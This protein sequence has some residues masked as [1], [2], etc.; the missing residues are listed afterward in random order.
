[1]ARS[2]RSSTLETRAARLR[3]PVARKPV[4][5][6]IGHGIGLG[7]R[8]NKTAGTWV[9]RVSDGKGGNWTKAIGNADDYDDADGT[10]TID[11]WQAQDKAR[12]LGRTERT[13]ETRSA[14]PATV[15]QALDDYEADLKTRGADAG[16][17]TRV[18]SHLPARLLDKAVALLL[19][20]EL[21]NWRDGLAGQLAAASVNR[22]ATG[23]KAALNLAAEQ[24]ARIA[25]RRA[26]EAGLA[27]IPD[28]EQS[29]NVILSET[30]VRQ[31]IVA[32][33]WQSAEFGLLI[34]VAAVTGARV[35]QLAQIEVQDLQADRDAPRLMMPTSRKGK[36]KKTVQRRPVPIPPRLAAKLRVLTADGPATA[37]LLVKPSG[38]PWKKSDHSRLFARAAEAAGQDPAQVTM[39]ALRHSNIVRQLLAGVPIRVVAVNHDTSIAMLERTYSR[40]IGDHSDA[41]ARVA[42][43]D[44]AEPAGSRVVSLHGSR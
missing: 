15:A 6:R 42:L 13:G 27:S 31:I 41:L 32:A 17:V 14:K 8:R 18:R 39:Y 11:F 38:A 23:L 44:T 10:A 20:R 35:S 9:A 1:M 4:F 7:Y 12:T 30:V 37:P 36:G 33:Q 5:V 28:A 19:S 24:D 3:L 25:N 43:L 34:E 21:R 2:T 29:R 22:T 26:W 40:H 16:N